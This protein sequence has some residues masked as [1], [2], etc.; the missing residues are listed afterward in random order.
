MLELKKRPKS[1]YWVARGTIQGRR[2]EV[3]TKCKRLSDAKEALPGIIAELCADTDGEEDEL[4]FV[5]ALDLYEQQHPNARFLAPIRRYFADMLVSEITNAE[6]RKAANALY[7][8]LAASTIRRQLYTPVKAVLNAAAEDD[9][10]VVRKLKAPTGGGRRTVFMLPKEAD[11]LVQALVADENGYLAPM[12]TF[13]LGQGCR[14]GET[15]SLAAADVSLEHRFA[16]LRDTKNDEERRIS[17]VPR[18]VA[19]LSTLPTIGRDG[20]L[21]RRENG[22]GF[23]VGQNSGGQIK[24]PFSRAVLAAGLDPKRITP[25]V[26][27]HTWATWFYAQTK[28]VRRL[29]NEGGWKSNEWQRYTKLGTPDLGH[30]VMR[31]GWDFREMGENRGKASVR[32]RKR[33]A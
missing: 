13:L 27:R 1:P 16:I 21:F 3:S 23:T 22:M 10:C 26:C 18:V 15:L 5:A 17:L 28:D 29:Q 9:L 8:G 2:V 12:V 31:A 19:A 32:P 11:A 24:S 30:S 6:M 33:W 4:S 7:P 25:H 20:P 14:M